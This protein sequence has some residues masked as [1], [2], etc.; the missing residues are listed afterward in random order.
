MFL[1]FA[2]VMT[3]SFFFGQS[4]M[5]SQQTTGGFFPATV[6]SSFNHCLST[7]DAMDCWIDANGVAPYTHANKWGVYAV[8]NSLQG[9]GYNDLDNPVKANRN[10]W[11]Y[12]SEWGAVYGV[13]KAGD[14]NLYGLVGACTYTGHN[15][16]NFEEWVSNAWSNTVECVDDGN[17]VFPAPDGGGLM[18]YIHAGGILR[19]SHLYGKRAS[20]VNGPLPVG[21]SKALSVAPLFTAS[22]GLAAH[23]SFYVVVSDNTIHLHTPSGWTT[24]PGKAQKIAVGSNDV[25]YIVDMNGSVQ[26]WNGTGWDP[27]VTSGP[28]TSLTVISA[29][30]GLDGGQNDVWISGTTGKIYRF[31]ETGMMFSHQYGGQVGCGPQVPTAECETFVH[32]LTHQICFGKT[33]CG[34]VSSSSW[35]G[36]GS[37]GPNANVF[38]RPNDMFSCLLVDDFA[39]CS[40]WENQGFMQ[41]SGGGSNSD[42]SGGPVPVQT[43]Y[44]YTRLLPAAGLPSPAKTKS[45]LLWLYKW[46]QPY[47]SNTQNPDFQPRFITASNN[48]E[49]VL[50]VS[51][52]C[53]SFLQSPWLCNGSL[54]TRAVGEFQQDPGTNPCTVC[55]P[56]SGTCQIP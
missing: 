11:T 54:I 51:S 48:H 36:N 44:A 52:L 20:W 30:W 2:L 18:M 40:A 28:V 8:N 13:F 17:D 9:F 14:G 43:E 47:C 45:G 12:H 26:H 29:G 35:N 49:L 19:Y 16:H 34:P 32:T 25:P 56:S 1:L 5:S 37:W 55:D 33:Q 24:L 31:W 7:N 22:D 6:E 21:Y 50:D 3:P 38:A 15:G 39:S 10:T 53:T 41:C 46:G 42:N 4:P 27:I 23:M